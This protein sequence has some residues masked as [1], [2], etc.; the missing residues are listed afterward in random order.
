MVL[1]GEV[2]VAAERWVDDRWP[3]SVKGVLGWAGKVVVLRNDR[4]EWE[5]PG[6]RLD[7][8]DA[9]PVDALRREM[10]EELGLDVA[11]GSLI[12]SWIYD[13]AGKRVL[14]V[15]YVCTAERPTALGHSNEHV[16]V[17]EFT[18]DALRSESIPDG[19]LRSIEAALHQDV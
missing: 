15:T 16:D 18:L 13:V 2:V 7:A 12:D 8:T 11:V 17:A 4:D 14:I 19:Y 6:G 1:S 3:V 5:L 10:Q 9:S